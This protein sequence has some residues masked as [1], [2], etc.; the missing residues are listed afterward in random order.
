MGQQSLREIE[1]TTVVPPGV[2]VEIDTDLNLRLSCQQPNGKTKHL[3]ERRSLT[4]SAEELENDPI[5]L[6]IMWNPVINITEQ[7]WHTVIRTAFSL[8]IGEAQD[9]AC[10]IL[11]AKGEQ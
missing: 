10:E 2:T 1:S 8:I 3:G 11:D 7:C 9:F 6:E 5:G 4:R